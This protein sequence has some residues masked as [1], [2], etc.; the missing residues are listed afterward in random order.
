MRAFE[1][2]ADRRGYAEVLDRMRGAAIRGMHDPLVRAWATRNTRHVPSGAQGAL[3]SALYRAVIRD[4]RFRED[5][6]NVFGM[7]RDPGVTLRE[8]A[9]NCIDQSALLASALQ[10]LGMRW[11]FKS[12]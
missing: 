6:R 7:I 1:T 9:G 8:G 12:Q 3:A 4:V 2:T 11:R 5:P 10:Y